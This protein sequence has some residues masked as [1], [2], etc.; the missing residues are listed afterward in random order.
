MDTEDGLPRLRGN[1]CRA[2]C[3]GKMLAYGLTA[4]C[5]R[6]FDMDSNTR[7]A[8]AADR[9]IAV[10]PISNWICERRSGYSSEDRDGYR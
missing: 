5:R 9:Q 4:S 1:S 8:D 10:R 2:A 6:R 3:H 7:Q